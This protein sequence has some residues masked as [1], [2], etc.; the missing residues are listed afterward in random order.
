MSRQGL[1]EGQVGG[2]DCYHFQVPGFWLL[3]GQCGARQGLV[4]Q[5]TAHRYRSRPAV[6]ACQGYW[7]QSLGKLETP[8]L[9]L[10]GARRS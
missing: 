10:F 7:T 2:L 4:L 8:I 1:Y 5:V 3:L 9:A 6:A